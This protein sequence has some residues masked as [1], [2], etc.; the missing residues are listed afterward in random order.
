MTIE[1]DPKTEQALKEAAAVRNVTVDALLQDFAAKE[2][3]YWQERKEDLETLEAMKNG[4]F[5]SQDEMFEKMDKMA[6]DAR[7]LSRNID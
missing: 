1:L 3:R 5:I 2:K 4:D 6:A 7:D